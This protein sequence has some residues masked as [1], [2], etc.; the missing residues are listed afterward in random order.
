MASQSPNCRRSKNAKPANTP[1]LYICKCNKQ[2]ATMS[3]SS[4]CSISVLDSI[5]SEPREPCV[6]N[7]RCFHPSRTASASSSSPL[8]KAEKSQR[9]PPDAWM[10]TNVW[11]GSGPWLKQLLMF[12][13]T[14]ICGNPVASPLSI[15]SLI[16]R[17][18]NRCS[19]RAAEKH[20]VGVVRLLRNALG[21]KKLRN[22]TESRPCTKLC[23][24]R[25]NN[26]N[27]RPCLNKAAPSHSSG[28]ILGDPMT[29]CKRMTKKCLDSALKN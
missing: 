10:G 4:A 28:S 29:S 27:S 2:K 21:T 23:P 24:H 20:S 22:T 8:N 15:A 18:M 16:V 11:S 19:S 26:G 5:K 7:A 14:K 3:P 12:S 1:R 9:P 25:N 6:C 17:L 13:G